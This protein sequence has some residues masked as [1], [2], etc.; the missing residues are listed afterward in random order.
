MRVPARHVDPL[1]HTLRLQ[2]LERE[3]AAAE[4]AAAAGASGSGGASASACDAAWALPQLCRRHAAGEGVDALVVSAD[5]ERLFTAGGRSGAIR[6]WAAVRA[7]C[8]DAQPLHACAPGHPGGVFALVVALDDR[9]CFSGGRDG[10]VRAAVRSAAADNRSAAHRG[11]KRLA[12][13]LRRCMPSHPSL[14]H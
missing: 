6:V 2:R 13:F 11:G 4:A 1:T 3:R 10:E 5:G 14:S 12:R 8:W 9:G 7:P